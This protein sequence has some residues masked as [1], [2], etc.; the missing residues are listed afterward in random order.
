MA[1]IRKEIPTWNI[2]W[3]NKVYTLL[4]DVDYVDDIWIDWAIY[5]GFTLVWK[6]LTLS[7][8]PTTSILVDYKTAD[9]TTIVTSTCTLWDMVSEVWTLLWQTWNSTTFSRDRVLLKLNGM[10]RDILRGRV[11]NVLNPRQ[12]FRAWKLWFIEWKN[13]FRIKA[14]STL[15]EDFNVWDTEITCDT[16]DLLGSWYIQIGADIV[17][18]TG[19]NLTW[20]TWCTWQTIDHID[21]EAMVQLYEAPLELEKPSK[22]NYIVKGTDL[23]RREITFDETDTR[24]T[25]YQILRDGTTVLFKVVW[26]SDWDLVETIYNV[27]YTDMS[28]DIEIC[29]LPDDYG[30]KVV[31][32]IVAG[33]LGYL[34]WLPMAQQTLSIGYWELQ[35]MFQY[36]TNDT[37][38]IRQSIAPQSYK[39]NSIKRGWY[40]R[41]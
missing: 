38:I 20:L 36:F 19:T 29:V 2:D 14:G 5:T 12:I 4:N 7:D 8:A 6:V 13:N 33:M 24:S 41:Y 9:S 31:A 34:H 1:D 30:T 40:V 26:L 25:Y 37:V 39:F 21:N 10:M 15:T 3:V 35:N 16:T 28:S 17:K 22:L 18:Y 32:P 27:S 11:T 23:R